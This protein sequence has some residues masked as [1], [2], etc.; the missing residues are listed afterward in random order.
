MTETTLNKGAM[1]R[2]RIKRIALALIKLTVS[3]AMLW[4]I[5]RS[6]ADPAAVRAAFATL[7][8]RLF[9]LAVA[10]FMLGQL[11]AAWRLQ[12]CLRALGR[13]LGY[14]SCLRAHWI[15]M[16]FNQALP[17]GF[18]G[19]VVKVLVLRR[20]G[21]TGRII[22]AVLGARLLGMASLF[23]VVLPAAVIAMAAMA[24]TAGTLALM[25]G[26]SLLALLGFAALWRLPRTPLAPV[27]RRRAPGRLGL[28]VARDFGRMLG[29]RYWR[30]Q[31]LTSLSIVISVSLVFMVLVQALGHELSLLW[32]LILPPMIVLAMQIPISL[33]GWGV[34]E[35]G[36]VMLLPMA[37]L[38][39]EI[40]LSASLLYGLVLIAAGL[41]GG[42][43]W[44]LPVPAAPSA[45]S[46][47]SPGQPITP[48]GVLA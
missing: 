17:G 41:P 21:H 2:K 3:A 9:A 26:L 19:D 33:A 34:R 18:G 47:P 39:V 32:A 6:I 25:A 15:G 8:W 48:K 30:V 13:W 4:L 37:G 23:V 1:P 36:A 31:A 46:A 43:A 27:I 22:R 14:R 20:P 42:L 24:M 7:D 40:A 38:P 29:R 12:A 44:W 28:T 5:F 45:P 11:F 35:A 10:I 16:F